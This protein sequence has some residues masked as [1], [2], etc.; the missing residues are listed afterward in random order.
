MT[1]TRRIKRRAEKPD[2]HAKKILKNFL[3]QRRKNVTK[4][5][6]RKEKTDF[7]MIY[8]FQFTEDC[9]VVNV[10]TPRSLDY[11][12]ENSKIL[13]DLPVLVWIHGGGFTLG[14]GTLPE[15]NARLMANV[16]NTVVVCVNYRIGKYTCCYYQSYPL[17]V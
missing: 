7:T 2:K 6:S 15:A 5:R 3:L 16:T 4:N 10:F 1:Q 8:I 14:A 13:G 11:D 12:E 9:L 17:T